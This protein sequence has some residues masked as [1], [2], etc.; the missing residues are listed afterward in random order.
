M[1][2]WW[3]AAAVVACSLG[4]VS[5][6][7][8]GDAGSPRSCAPS[9]VD[10]TT[11]GRVSAQQSARGASVAWGVAP[12][13]RYARIVV[14]VHAGGRKVDGKD[15]ASDPRGVVPASKIRKAGPGAVFRVEGETYDADGV[16]TSF[17][18]RCTLG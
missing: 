9:V 16:R 7:N 5:C 11:F 14:R 4:L 18:L 17:F 3:P 6:E 13:G 10:R 1:T 12:A 2:R 15:Q 8:V